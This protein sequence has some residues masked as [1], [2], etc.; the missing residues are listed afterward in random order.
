M[1]IARA[2]GLSANLASEAFVDYSIPRVRAL[3]R[4]EGRSRIADPAGDGNLT[5]V[6][7]VLVLAR[8]M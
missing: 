5:Q 7:I 8:P 3:V 6:I 4:L 2:H 1:I